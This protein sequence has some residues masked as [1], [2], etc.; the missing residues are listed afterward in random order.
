MLWNTD[1]VILSGA[2]VSYPTRTLDYELSSK[3]AVSCLLESRLFI[4]QTDRSC[5][6]TKLYLLYHCIFT[7]H[8]PYMSCV[9]R[10]DS[11]P[12]AC[13]LYTRDNARFAQEC[14]STAIPNSFDALY[15]QY[16]P[17]SRR[18][19]YTTVIILIIPWAV[20]SIDESFILMKSCTFRWISWEIRSSI[21]SL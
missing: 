6:S 15:H 8:A 13:L 20:N 21:R 14:F 12:Q 11:L 19:Y 2:T 9:S 4:S 17:S 1:E 10:Q 16:L 5:G 3:S 7:V 18:I